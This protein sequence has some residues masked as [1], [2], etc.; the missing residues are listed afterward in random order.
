M[1][2]PAS[3]SPAEPGAGRGVRRLSAEDLSILALETET[4]AGHTCKVIMLGGEIDLDR[5]RSSISARLHRAPELCMRLSEIDA[6]PSW[7]QQ[8]EVD[9]AAHVGLCDQSDARDQREFRATVARLFKQRLDR[10]RPLWRIDVVPRVEPVG[11]ALVWRMHH[12]LADG[13]TSMRIARAILWDEEP[14]AEAT[15]RAVP[16]TASA[17]PVTH[18][19]FGAMSSVLRE[20]PQPWLRSPF[21]GHIGTE[22]EVAFTSAPL[23]GL[24]RVARATGGATVNDAV[25]TVVAGGIRRWL[26]ARHGRLR[27]VR[28]KVPVSLHD[29]S[30]GHGDGGTEPGNR[31]SFFCLDMP[32]GPADPLERLAEVSR[33]TTVRKQGHDAQY[34]DELMRELACVP[35]LRQF[36]EHVLAHPRSFAL[37]VS[38]VPGP[39][40]PVAVLRV[41]V[42]SFYVLGEIREHHALRIAAVSIGDTVTFGLTADPTLLPDV[43][44]LAEE[45]RAEA[46]ALIACDPRSAR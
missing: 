16:H 31:D 11:A 43:D 28:V 44:R 41:P 20:A 35:Q 36:A 21:D 18:R 9:I 39:R 5:L 13:A 23:D 27:R 4:V 1:P 30:P 10:A 38:N 15:N 2:G 29:E 17:R 8:D 26:E 14:T 24:H 32:L 45:M 40:Q 3:N 12:A 42:R 33:A 19:R 46:D 22:R 7:V 6:V 37:S 34:L 25:L